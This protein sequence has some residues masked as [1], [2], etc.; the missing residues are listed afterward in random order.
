MVFFLPFPV[1]IDVCLGCQQEFMAADVFLDN[2]RRLDAG[3]HVTD[4]IAVRGQQVI[5]IGLFKGQIGVDQERFELDRLSA[6]GK[7]VGIDLA[8]Y[9]VGADFKGKGRYIAVLRHGKAA[10]KQQA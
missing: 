10:R 6:I 3:H 4:F 2:Q 1:T 8:L 9:T 5:F 7:R